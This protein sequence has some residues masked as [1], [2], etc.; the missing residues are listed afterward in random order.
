VAIRFG[1][2]Q[3]VTRREYIDRTGFVATAPLLVGGLGAIDRCCGVAQRGDRVM[4]GGLVGF[5][6]SDQMNAGAGRLLEC[7]F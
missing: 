2:G 1:V 7:F 4:Q 6:L 3:A 5:D